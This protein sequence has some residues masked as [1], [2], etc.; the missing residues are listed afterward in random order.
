MTREEANKKQRERRRINGY[1][2]SKKYEKTRKGFLMRVYRNMLSRVTGVVKNKQHLYMGKSI[3]DKNDFYEYSLTNE[4]F[5]TL[6]D[7]WKECGCDRKKTPSIDR[8]DPLKGYDI[9]NVQWV[10]F[11]ENCSRVRR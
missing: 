2:N 6:F 5:N 11:S 9:D 3:M 1:K 7:E 8:I 10:T 4:R